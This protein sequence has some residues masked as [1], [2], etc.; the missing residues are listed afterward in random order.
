MST[1]TSNTAERLQF[2]EYYRTLT[3][4]DLA[5]LALYEDLMPAAREA[6]TEELEARG[7]R[8]L[9]SFQKQFEEDAI[10]AKAEGLSAF[11]PAKARPPVQKDLARNQQLLGLTGLLMFGLV[12]VHKWLLGD[13]TTW[14]KEE[15][16]AVW[17]FLGLILIWD[18]MLRVVRGQASKKLVVW[19]V[20][21]LLQI[22]MPAAVLAVPALGRLVSGYGSPL[23]VA[24]LFS[25]AIAFAVHRGVKRIARR[26]L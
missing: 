3:D 22:T 13:A 11:T 21:A 16:L 5:R 20:L 4:N 6:I 10:L 26:S 8:D 1:E 23:V 19:L 18:P 15:S 25:P 9:S 12:G 7:L 2:R 17:L 24:I 14:R